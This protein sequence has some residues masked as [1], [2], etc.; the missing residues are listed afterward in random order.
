M[1]WAAFVL[2]ADAA[3]CFRPPKGMPPVL[4][5]IAGFLKARS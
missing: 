4:G 1:R 3:D 2:M 5:D